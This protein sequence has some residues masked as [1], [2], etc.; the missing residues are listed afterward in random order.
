M[1]YTVFSV[2]GFSDGGTGLLSSDITPDA[3]AGTIVIDGTPTGS[4]SAVFGVNVID[5]VGAT[6]AEV[7]TITV[8]GVNQSPTVTTNPASA[9]TDAGLTTPVSFMAAAAGARPPW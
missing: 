4:G 9:A 3:S 7:Y 8:G 5:S 2:N 6:L 1:P